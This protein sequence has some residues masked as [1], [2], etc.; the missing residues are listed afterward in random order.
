MTEMAEKLASKHTR[1]EIEEIAE[2]LGINTIGISKLKL[3]EAIVEARKKAPGEEKPKTKG[4]PAARST[5]AIGKSGVFA[6]KM[7]MGKKAMEIDTFVSELQRNATEIRTKGITEMQ[8][9]INAQIR[10]NEKG[11]SK[12]KSGVKEMQ[13]GIEQMRADIEKKSMELQ[14]GV[15]EMH[16]GVEEI[17]KSTRE[18][19]KSFRDFQNNTV[20]YIRDFYYG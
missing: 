14:K 20:D 13:R 2:R 17:Q 15:I 9:G 10:D 5:E 8:K 12:M 4:K 3:C 7:D 16:R 18:M 19:E 11:A 1:R 6:L